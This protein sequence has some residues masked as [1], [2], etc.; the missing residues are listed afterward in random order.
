MIPEVQLQQYPDVVGCVI[1]LS[2][3]TMKEVYEDKSYRTKNISYNLGCEE[4]IDAAKSEEIDLKWELLMKIPEKW[5][6]DFRF[7]EE[8]INDILALISQ[9][10]IRI[11]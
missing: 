4:E 5:W 6:K 9:K 8:N 7:Q 3:N 11:L 1:E 2:I 10:V